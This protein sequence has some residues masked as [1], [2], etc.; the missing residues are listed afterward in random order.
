MDGIVKC[1]RCRLSLI[2]EES[3]THFCQRKETDYRLE[4]SI[5]WFFDGFRWFK[6]KLS[7]ES[8][9]REDSDEELPE[10]SLTLQDL[11][12]TRGCILAVIYWCQRKLFQ[13]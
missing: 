10:P 13:R 2:E 3:D 9:H 12:T 6:H 1:P 4:G 5:L 7:D 8:Y 11:Y